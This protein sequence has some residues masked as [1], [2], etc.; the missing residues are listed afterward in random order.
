MKI[1]SFNT[2][3]TTT[4]ACLELFVWNVIGRCTRNIG[5][6]ILLFIKMINIRQIKVHLYEKLLTIKYFKKKV[7]VL[8]SKQEKAQSLCETLV[9]KFEAPKKEKSCVYF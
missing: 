7:Q 2:E 3:K 4:L 8:R 5:F 1:K 6:I 9:S